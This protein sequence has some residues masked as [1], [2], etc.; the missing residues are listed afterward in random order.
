MRWALAL[1]VAGC[2]RIDFDSMSDASSADVIAVDCPTDYLPV[3]GSPQL[4]TQSFCA[5]QTEARAWRDTNGNGLLDTTELDDDGCETTLC[6]VNWTSPGYL[7]VS[8]LPGLADPWR[9]VSQVVAQ[10]GCRALGARFDLMSNREWM[11][12]ARSAELISSNW[13]GGSPGSGRLVEGH[14]DGTPDYQSVA[15][16]ADPYTGTGNDASQLPDVGW[17]QR[18]TIEYAPGL[19]IWDLTGHLQEWVDWTTGDALDGVPSPCTT[20]Q[21]PGYA[22]PGLVAEDFQSTTGTYDSLMGAGRV[23]GGAGNAVRRGGQNG[24]RTMGF[25]GI[26]A[27][28]TNRDRTEIFGG[29]GFRCVFRP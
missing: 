22:C 25:A 13:S 20:G 6:D 4:G 26:Y 8:P 15:D 19:V 29:T 3:M 7:P 14:T 5:M 2:G 10:A 23:I 21:L 24:D 16:P 18:R 9:S 28:N 1:L 17:E 27:F 11:T 12:I